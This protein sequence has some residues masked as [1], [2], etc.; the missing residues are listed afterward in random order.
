MGLIADIRKLIGGESKKTVEDVEHALQ[1]VANE[2]SAANDALAKGA[3]RR[4]AA[5]LD[6]A[7]N[8]EIS[9]MDAE[10]EGHRVTL[11]RC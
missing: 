8:H 3:E 9:A 4:R 11:E 10:L 6:D 5:L 2:R 7:S 1:R